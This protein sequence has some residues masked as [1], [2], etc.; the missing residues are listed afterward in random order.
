[1]YL[2][3]DGK[4]TRKGNTD[5][6]EPPNDDED[7][8]Q[9]GEDNG[10]QKQYPL[11]IE[12]VNMIYS[13]NEIKRDRKPAIRVVYAAEPVVPQFMP[14]SKQLI[15]FVQRDHLTSMHHDGKTASSWTW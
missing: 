7:D 6:K 15:S 8:G 2:Q 12:N 1:M 14:W 9:T 3:E 10:G 13:C 5:K 11:L 4:L